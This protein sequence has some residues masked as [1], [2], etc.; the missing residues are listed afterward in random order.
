MAMAKLRKPKHRVGG[1]GWWQLRQDPVLLITLIIISISLFIFIVYPL[2]K[3]FLLSIRPQGFLT[4][5]VYR[6]VLSQW[7]LR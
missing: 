3:V 4:L 5:D 2:L 7:W 6:G 1:T